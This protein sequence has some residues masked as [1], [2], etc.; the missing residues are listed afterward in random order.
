MGLAR[1]SVAAVL[2]V[3]SC[4]A[5]AS[6]STR[7]N[8]CDDVEMATIRVTRERLI[9]LGM[10]DRLDVYLKEPFVSIEPDCSSLQMTPATYTFI[11]EF[12][13]R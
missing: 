5:Q 1:W 6:G 9:Q 13:P 12:S 11:S 8:P 7:L 3:L 10:L 2:S 4:S